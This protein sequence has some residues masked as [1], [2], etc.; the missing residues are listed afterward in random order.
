[1]TIKIFSACRTAKL[2][3]SDHGSNW[4]RTDA[5]AARVR[6]FAEGWEASVAVGG[7]GLGSAWFLATVAISDSKNI[8]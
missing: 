2:D 1:M 8:D 7:K 3:S 4:Q 5:A 6:G